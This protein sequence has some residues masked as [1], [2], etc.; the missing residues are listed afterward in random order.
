MEDEEI[1]YGKATRRGRQRQRAPPAGKTPYSRPPARPAPVE[2]PL[3]ELPV[4]E[5]ARG[6]LSSLLARPWTLGA[7]LISKVRHCF[8]PRPSRPLHRDWAGR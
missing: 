7:S 8:V 3:D 2:D 6:I 4:S 1:G 5:P